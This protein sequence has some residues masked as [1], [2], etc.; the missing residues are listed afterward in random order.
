MRRRFSV[1]Q[2][3]AL[4]VVALGALLA[5]F[6][7]YWMFSAATRLSSEVLGIPPRL[8]IGTALITNLQTLVS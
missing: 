3:L 2:T 4:I 1:L 7:F 8:D 5:V 6:P